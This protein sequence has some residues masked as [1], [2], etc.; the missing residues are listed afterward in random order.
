MKVPKTTSYFGLLFETGIWRIAEM[1]L[2]MKLMLIH[3][4]MHSSPERLIRR[5]IEEQDRLQYQG[6]WLQEL[7]REA[8]K[9]EIIVDLNEI[10]QMSKPKYKKAMKQQIEKKMI[11]DMKNNAGKKMRTVVEDGFRRKEYIKEGKFTEDEI[12]EL[13]KIRLHMGNMKANYRDGSNTRC[14]FCDRAE[15]TTEHVLTECQSIEYLRGD[16][17]ITTNN[18]QVMTVIHSK[19]IIEMSRR[20]NL[21][22]ISR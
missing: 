6:C 1:I 13:L 4:I 11:E 3:N 19:A 20:I 18:L 22:M 5:M 16:L 15:E 10:Q 7:R 14:Q 12:K 21:I 8:E 17:P 9:R 2:Y